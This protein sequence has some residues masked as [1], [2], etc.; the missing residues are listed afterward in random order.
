MNDS[1]VSILSEHVKAQLARLAFLQEYRQ[2]IRDP[3]V[4]S[5]L[6]FVI[7][8]TQEAI[9]RVASRLRQLDSTVDESLD[10]SGQ[11]LLRQA[12][13]RRSLEDKIKFIRQGLKHQTEW[14]NARMKDLRNDADSQAIFVGLAEQARVRLDRWENMM[15][16]LKVSLD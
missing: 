8:D 16:D 12:Q 5:A 3:Y 9:A 7:E 10:E 11:K 1:S 4:T 13:S 6:A 14:Y 2:R 15:K